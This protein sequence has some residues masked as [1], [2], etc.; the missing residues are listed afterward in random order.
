[1]WWLT[2]SVSVL[3]DGNVFLCNAVCRVQPLLCMSEMLA[4][5][6]E[7]GTELVHPVLEEARL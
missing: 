6:Q 1:M 5:K 4:H 2:H 3:Q 7:P